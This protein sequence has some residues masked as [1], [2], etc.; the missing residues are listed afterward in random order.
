MSM[1]PATP[2]VHKQDFREALAPLEIVVHM[3]VVVCFNEILQGRN[4]RALNCH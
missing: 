1:A 3:L 2:C 4:I